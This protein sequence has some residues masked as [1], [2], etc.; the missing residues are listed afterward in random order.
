MEAIGYDLYVKI[1][2]DAVNAEKGVQPKAE[3]NCIV[4]LQVDAYIPES[5]I[6]S[7]RL[8]MDVYRKI[9]TVSDNEEKRDL[10]DE[11]LDRFGEPPKAVQN[12]VQVSLIRHA[13]MDAGFTQIEERMGI[14]SLYH[15]TMDAEAAIRI[16]HAPGFRGRVMLTMSGRMHIAVRMPPE[17]D[18]L[19]D[20]HKILN[21][22][23]NFSQKTV[24]KSE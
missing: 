10:E 12:L 18:L 4:D 11:L 13:A 5:Y 20:V 6:A 22:Y 1:L 23:I 14:V 16:P 24:D 3:R 17:T 21:L 7:S 9:V 2:E 15:P 19:G 8:R